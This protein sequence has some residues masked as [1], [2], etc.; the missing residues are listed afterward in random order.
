MTWFYLK[1]KS[2]VIIYCFVDMQFKLM[3]GFCHQN[4]IPGLYNWMRDFLV[5]AAS[6]CRLWRITTCRK[7][8]SFALPP[9]HLHSSDTRAIISR[10]SQ[11][12]NCRKSAFAVKL[13]W[14]LWHPVVSGLDMGSL[15]KCWDNKLILMFYLTFIMNKQTGQ[16]RFLPQN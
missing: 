10:V 16:S 1:Q 3:D 2:K 15:P 8:C 14:F 9:H 5:Y 6:D 13:N 4:M 12:Y 11:K 7:F